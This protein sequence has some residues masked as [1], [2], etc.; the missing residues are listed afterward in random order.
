MHVFVLILPKGIS[1]K[2]LELFE[3]RQLDHHLETMCTIGVILTQEKFNNN[4]GWFGFDRLEVLYPKQ[5][6][7]CN[8]PCLYNFAYSQTSPIVKHDI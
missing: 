3:F 6:K 8:L 1:H 2:P 5:A 4:V 7:L